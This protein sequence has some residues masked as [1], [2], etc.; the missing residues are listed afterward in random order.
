MIVGCGAVAQRL[1][2][3]PLRQL[4][5]QGI[6]RVAALVD[7]VE[8]HGAALAAHFPKAARFR[9]LEDALPQVKPQLSLVLSPAHLHAEQTIAAFAA[10][11]HVFCEKPMANSAADC[12]RMEAAAKAAGRV[13]GIGMIRRYY[14]AFAQLKA[15]L[16]GGRLGA[17]TSFEYREGHKFEWE[18]TTA[19]AFR[20]RSQGGTGV[21]FD[22]GPHV[23][24][25][26]AWTFG[27]LTVER[28][29]DDALA[30]I[31]SNMSMDVT[32]P[33]CRG[34]IHLSWDTP[35]TNDLRVFGTR[36]EAVV[37]IDRFDQLAVRTTGGYEPQPITVTFPADLAAAP[38]RTVTP[39]SYPEAVFCQLVQMARAIV[40][41]EPPAVDGDCGRRT[42]AVL[43]SA[44]T[45]ARP[46]STPWL[47]LP[48]QTAF[49]RLHWTH[50]R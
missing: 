25:H 13:L 43:E 44:L 50:A 7:P 31:E 35:Q 39:R 2:C 3:K 1:Y 21:L 24:D 17:L 16:D 28:Y 10:G 15:I 14:P 40:L 38:Q 29:T 20:P 45:V 41:G 8:G 12:A 48:E 46:L 49:S 11:S 26:L 33:G 37:R 4:E 9:T 5:K 34:S 6:L 47:D 27:A 36:G 42:T 18:I 22:I 19:A 30:G 23:V 32:A